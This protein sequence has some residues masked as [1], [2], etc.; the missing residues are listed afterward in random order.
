MT[1]LDLLLLAGIAGLAASAALAQE[2][3]PPAPPDNDLAAFFDAVDVR[4]VNLDV[5]VVDS[6]GRTVADLVR[7][8]FELLEGGRPVE[9]THFS[10]FGTQR[11][12]TPAAGVDPATAPATAAPPAPAAEAPP[13]TWIIYVDPSRVRST[14]KNAALRAMEE[15]LHGAVR[16]ADRALVAVWQGESL[17]ILSRLDQGI[18]AALDGIAELA[19]R[20]GSAS[21]LNERIAGLRRDINELAPLTVNTTNAE[22]KAPMRDEEALANDSAAGFRPGTDGVSKSILRQI[23]I[24]A[25]QEAFRARRSLTALADLMNLTAGIDGRIAV[26][27]LG[28]GYDTRPFDGLFQLW[29]SRFDTRGM[30]RAR[31]LEVNARIARI[32]DGYS[33][34][35]ESLESGRAT[36]YTIFAGDSAEMGAGADAVDGGDSMFAG[37]SSSAGASTSGRF[38]LGALAD[39]TGGRTFVA[40]PALAARLA[41]IRSDQTTYYSIGYRPGPDADA[42]S[43]IAVKLRRD[44]L[45]ARFRGTP[46]RR[47]PEDEAA[48]SALSVLLAPATTGGGASIELGEIRPAE[49][50]GEQLVSITVRVPIRRLT[51][52]PVG[53][54]LRGQLAYFIAVEDADG[55]FR[56]VDP[57]RQDFEVDSQRLIDGGEGSV[58]YRLDLPLPPG[59]HRLGVAVLDEPSGERLTAALPVEIVG[60]R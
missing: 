39:A 9:I 44:G 23:E 35:L 25:E 28:G 26:L 18:D 48:A 15:F 4:L 7:E 1:R 10:A 27:V 5:V 58:A 47:T 2:P 12:G 49:R 43:R 3:P 24:A 36:I 50:R 55:S 46:G 30:G 45:V 29:A 40:G 13:T 17:H 56:R 60:G 19:R 11:V 59:K 41:D 42:R 20:P 8:D 38:T 22:N 37:G 53:Q 57:R 32:N 31:D 14:Q 54:V 21:D 16:P 33:D 34:F 51:L 52:L 6:E